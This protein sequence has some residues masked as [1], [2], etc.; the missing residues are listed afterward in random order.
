M[1]EFVNNNNIPNTGEKHESIEDA[2]KRTQ[3][4]E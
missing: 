2:I 4:D 1:L 3:N